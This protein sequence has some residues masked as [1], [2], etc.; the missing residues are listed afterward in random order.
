MNKQFALAAA[1][2]LL[3]GFLFTAAGQASA[4][5]HHPLAKITVTDTGAD[6]ATFAQAFANTASEREALA[7]APASTLDIHGAQFG[8]VIVRG[9]SAAQPTVTLCK[10]ARAEDRAGADQLLRNVRLM[11]DGGRVWVTAPLISG[12]WA[13]ALIVSVP[14]GQTLSITTPRGVTRLTGLS[15]QVSVSTGGTVE[16]DGFSGKLRTS[17]ALGGRTSND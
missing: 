5:G 15:G 4:A 14:R 2:L 12:E 11:S 7:L 1:P 17:P 6:C 10:F 3:L 9:T 13:A 8:P 16:T